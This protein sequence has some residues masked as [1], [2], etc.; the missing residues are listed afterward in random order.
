VSVSG[1]DPLNK[2]HEVRIWNVTSA[3]ALT[4]PVKYSNPIASVAFSPDGRRLVIVGTDRTARIWDVPTGRPITPPLQQEENVTL[5]EFSPDGRRLLTA[6]SQSVRV[7]DAITGEPI[8]PPLR[9]GVGIS[10]LG[11]LSDPSLAS[12]DSQWW[13][14]QGSWVAAAAFTSDRRRLVTLNDS[15]RVQVWDL[16]PDARPLR[17]LEL[18]V[19]LLSGRRI[20][21]SG[22]SPAVIREVDWQ[23]LKRTYPEAFTG[24]TRQTLAWRRAEAQERERA[25]TAEGPLYRNRGAGHARNG[26]FAE[27]TADFMRAAK[28]GAD[29]A[30]TRTALALVRLAMHDDAA[31]RQDRTEL[32]KRFA[33]TGD[34]NTV[35]QLAHACCVTPTEAAEL[36]PLQD[37]IQQILAK[38]PANYW[39]AAAHGLVL[40][41]AGRFAEAV[42]RI[43]AA[44]AQKPVAERGA[45]E[46][47][48]LAMAQFRLGRHQDARK[49]LAEAQQYI[50][51]G[52]ATDWQE[53]LELEHLRR[54]A[55]ALI[56]GIPMGR[57]R[58]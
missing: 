47:L 28:L 12:E 45:V 36:K 1:D 16:S 50:D 35:Q 13:W 48:F 41:R 57:R 22:A 40:H 23:K 43:K 21:R 55:E 20:D 30:E 9:P 56:Q 34:A 11:Y 6:T 3:R 14:P 44:L 54:E 24:S 4:L 5:A 7:W 33:R 31:Y 26:R 53:R 15:H 52:K 37:S 42:E 2:K 39:F 25:R 49:G 27:A 32:L 18:L 10:G 46:Q 58:E 19:R 8:T 17:D 51:K 29:D 38:Q